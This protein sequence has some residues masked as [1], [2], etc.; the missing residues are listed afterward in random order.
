MKD[1]IVE[2]ELG[3]GGFLGFCGG[4]HAPLVK[5]ILGVAPVCSRQDV[6]NRIGA[7]ERVAGSR[8]TGAGQSGAVESCRLS[9]GLLVLGS[10]MAVKPS[11]LIW[12]LAQMDILTI[13]VLK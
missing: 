7:V 2:L 5:R 12:D 9:A 4:T 13:R 3:H 11:A 8:Q 10:A 1:E 6:A